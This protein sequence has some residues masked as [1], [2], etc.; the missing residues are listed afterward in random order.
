[1]PPKTRSKLRKTPTAMQLAKSRKPTGRINK[2]DIA[3]AVNTLKGLTTAQKAK[4][5]NEIKRMGTLPS[6]DALK[7]AAAE[8]RSQK[9]QSKGPAGKV[10]KKKR[11]GK[12]DA[13]NLNIKK[14][15]GKAILERFQSK[16]SRARKR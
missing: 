4:L 5:R 12:V 13:T 3:N 7:S 2:D 11:G 6:S 10:M 9:T 16:N 1:M 8:I 14:K 15:Y